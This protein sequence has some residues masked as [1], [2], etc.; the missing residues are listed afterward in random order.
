MYCHTDLAV[1]ER[2]KIKG[3]KEISGVSLK[4]EEKAGGNI[5]VTTVEILN[6]HGA[7]VMGK[8]VGVYVTIE[9]PFVFEND[10]M[11]K[12]VSDEITHVLNK[13][14]KK[15]PMENVLVAGLGNKDVTPDMLGPSVIER[16]CVTRHLIEE[17]KE[18]MCKIGNMAKTSAICP[19][20]M[21]QTGIETKEILKGVI[22][23]AKA[24]CLI[25]IDALAARSSSRLNRTIQ[26][27]DTGICPGSGVGNHRMA[28][29]K[30]SMGVPVIA[31][32][33][34]TVIDE[35]TMVADSIEI[36]M[37]NA[38]L[39]EDETQKVIYDYIKNSTGNM[40]VTPKDI[41][42]AVIKIAKVIAVGINN[43]LIGR[44]KIFM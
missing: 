31:I 1:E 38:G 20:V 5:T 4:K 2:E 35:V 43:S 33:V 25:V 8:P 27:T 15:L 39:S 34:P 6:E 37:K 14:K 21:S 24:D 17:Y 29:N 12:N 41:D 11:T 10:K 36:Y 7:G 32:G 13:M 44:N 28:I 3:N 16:L 22:E 18:E 30:E 40:I 42:E 23:G 19:G 26:I 9:A